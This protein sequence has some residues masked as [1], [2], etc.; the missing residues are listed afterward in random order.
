M[1]CKSCADVIALTL[2]KRVIQ[3]PWLLECIKEYENVA[4]KLS[5]EI[6]S[7][8]LDFVFNTMQNLDIL[9]GNGYDK[10]I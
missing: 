5:E 2:N 3:K 6:H 9:L 8:D 7:K 1:K 4:I 10:D